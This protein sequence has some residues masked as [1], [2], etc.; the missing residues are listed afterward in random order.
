MPAPDQIEVS[1]EGYKA[2]C[3]GVPLERG[4]EASPERGYVHP[5]GLI[6]DSDPETDFDSGATRRAE[7]QTEF[8]ED[9]NPENPP[10]ATFI[11][12][13]FVYIA[14]A[15]ARFAGGLSHSP[16]VVPFDGSPDC[17]PSGDLRPCPQYHII[18]V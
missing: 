16:V 15:E 5:G 8:G 13:K 4:G 11:L 10:L 17:A 12:V 14:I 6:T 7:V 2:R 3:S 18:R 9:P 1:R